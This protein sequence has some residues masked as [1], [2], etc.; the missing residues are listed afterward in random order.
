MRAG[1]SRPP[2]GGRASGSQTSATQWAPTFPYADRVE[3]DKVAGD[4][5]HYNKPVRLLH[6]GYCCHEVGSQVVGT[7]G[8]A[9]REKAALTTL[10][11]S[12]RQ[13]SSPGRNLK[14]LLGAQ[15]LRELGQGDTRGSGGLL[16]FL[17][18]RKS[19]S[20]RKLALGSR[21]NDAPACRRR[22]G[23]SLPYFVGAYCG[24]SPP[25]SDSR[26]GNVSMV[27]CRMQ[28]PS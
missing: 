21:P 4:N 17:A 13:Q 6:G 26:Y 14:V 19:S 28:D 27:T 1:G 18:K 2:E 11:F 25:S 9:A 24:S 10:G 16:G 22:L 7:Q 15:V 20:G 8:E 12:F 23:R 3:I 5:L